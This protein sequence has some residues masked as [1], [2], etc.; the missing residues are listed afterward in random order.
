M[1]QLTNQPCQHIQ[2]QTNHP[3]GTDCGKPLTPESKSSYPP[4]SWTGSQTCGFSGYDA[5]K[6]RWLTG[7]PVGR[8][9]APRFKRIVR[10]SI[11]PQTG[12][13]SRASDSV[14]VQWA[15]LVSCIACPKR[16]LIVFTEG[17]AMLLVLQTCGPLA[18]AFESGHLF[19]GV[20]I[21]HV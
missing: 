14:C 6:I 5:Y 11:L 3:K 20:L 7:L 15:R 4:S 9:P 2:P 18:T 17:F 1:D 12:R 10:K 8:S 13:P 16:K 21:Q 19:P